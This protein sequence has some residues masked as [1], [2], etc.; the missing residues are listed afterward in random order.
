MGGRHR[1]DGY[2]ML[3]KSDGQWYHISFFLPYFFQ[4]P[5]YFERFIVRVFGLS[6]CVGL[7]WFFLERKCLWLILNLKP[8]ARISGKSTTLASQYRKTAAKHCRMTR[9][10]DPKAAKYDYS[11]SSMRGRCVLFRITVG[12]LWNSRSVREWAFSWHCDDDATTSSKYFDVLH[13]DVEK[14]SRLTN[15]LV[16]CPR[17]WSSAVSLVSR[18]GDVTQV[19]RCFV[20]LPWF[21]FNG[22]DCLDI[23]RSARYNSV[24][25]HNSIIVYRPSGVED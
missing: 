10:G 3:H 15:V 4:I 6:S 20:F 14:Y 2:L 9:E 25:W 5:T 23:C 13:A 11:S 7:S 24:Y 21:F 22:T 8:C 17:R 12:T 1:D 19:I 18:L 16:A